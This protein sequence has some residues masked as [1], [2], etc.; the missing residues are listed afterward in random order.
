[1]ARDEHVKF[2]D[3]YHSAN[4]TPFSSDDAPW[5]ILCSVCIAFQATELIEDH[6][7]SIIKP[8]S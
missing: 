2:A 3:L 6:G 5:V 7:Q 8:I 4:R 1:M